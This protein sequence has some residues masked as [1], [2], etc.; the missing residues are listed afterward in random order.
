[1]TPE[2]ARRAAE[3]FEAALCLPR[4]ERAAFL[5]QLDSEDPEVRREAES[6]LAADAQAGATADPGSGE[7]DDERD[8]TQPAL[9]SVVG[10][11]RLLRRLGRG[12]MSTVYLGERCDG[13]LAQ[14]VAVKLVDRG[15]GRPGFLRRLETERQIL[16]QLDHP[17][18]TRIFDAG[19][20]ADGVPYVVMEHVDGEPIDAYCDSRRLTIRDRLALFRQ[21]CRAVHYAH[22]NLVIHRDLKPS[23]I[24]VTA[25]GQPKLLDFGIAK[26]LAPPLAGAETTRA[27]ERLLT[28]EYAS[29]EQL[30]GQRMATTS[31]VYSLGVVLFK[32]LTGTLPFPSRFASRGEFERRVATVDADR[33]S[34]VL[35][36][37]LALSASSRPGGSLLAARV[38][39]ARATQPRAL[40]RELTGDLDAI[41]AKA[42]RKAPAERYLSAEQLGEDVDRYLAGLPVRA[43][44]GGVRY[45]MG[46]FLQRHRLAVGSAAAVLVVA[47]ATAVAVA[48]Q[49]S[50]LAEQRATALRERDRADAVVSF[51]DGLLRSGNAN[52]PRSETIT[53]LALLDGGMKRIESDLRGQ[54]VTQADLLSTMGAMYLDLGLYRPARRA[55]ARALAM[56]LAVPRA[57]GE[58]VARSLANLA[59]LDM[60]AGR[61]GAAEA[62]ARRALD[63]RGR[64]LGPAHPAVARTRLQLGGILYSEG[65]L[66]EAES[67]LRALLPALAAE[68][69]P[70]P[71]RADVLSTLGQVVWARGR[72]REAAPLLAEAVALQRRTQ[73]EKSWAYAV[74][75]N[76]LALAD[77]DLG[78]RDTAAAL[79]RRSEDLGRTLYGERHALHMA[80]LNN[81]ALLAADRG[82]ETTAEALYTAGLRIARDLFPPEAPQLSYPLVG[83]G[84]VL[85]AR[86]DA[87]GA[88][89]LLRQAVD[90]RRQAL[91]PGSGLTRHAESLLALCVRSDRTR[92]PAP[93][94]G[95]P[96]SSVLIPRA[97]GWCVP[98]GGV[99]DTLTRTS[100]CSGTAIAGTTVC[101]DRRD[102]GTTWTSCLQF[103][104]TRLVGGCVPAG[105][106]DDTLA[107][108][109]CCSGRSVPGSTRCLD[110]ADY[111]T[112]WKSCV[113]TCA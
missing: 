63:L 36:R 83:L 62:F 93:L 91:A 7:P 15:L 60:G 98:D 31:D 8:L 78:R 27:W 23:N 48:V 80:A 74:A 110:P 20:T 1:M 3:I 56:R 95:D 103:C 71:L 65:R 10:R 101:L 5:T 64:R 9:G 25:A 41:V 57:D 40:V 13:E 92:H 76:D 87:H 108:T 109:A 14:Q 12:G 89:P 51:L 59:E 26:L 18:I 39:S 105:G 19:R 4:E 47:A 45:R 32:L 107:G 61:F 43:R 111:G 99:D 21:V 104:G 33:P 55:F 79:L 6:L 75:L 94:A 28:P 58:L 96:L 67:A 38:A 54:P 90:I 106:V 86:G 17:A 66:A 50:R 102:R 113:Q 30:L 69:R 97:S 22:Q 42:L 72:A 37:L 85:L 77:R 100:C 70:S 46:R 34:A 11:F 73:G 2:Q 16:A 29:P 82:D 49:A 84:G 53:A 68:T 81:L 35:G 112:T 52:G 24:L 44:R 88:E